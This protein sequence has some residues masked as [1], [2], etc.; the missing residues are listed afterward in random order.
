MDD[1]VLAVSEAATNALA[2]SGTAEILVRCTPAERCLEVAVED[3][4]MFRRQVPM[5]EIEGAGGHGISLML[6]LMDEVSIRQGTA[7]RPGTVVRLRK[8]PEP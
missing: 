6:A 4:G 3:R 7:E 8:C 5:P 2:H 1:L